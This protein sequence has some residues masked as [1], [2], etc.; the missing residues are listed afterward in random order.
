MDNYKD[1]ESELSAQ[2]SEN[3]SQPEEKNN[4]L[5]SDMNNI[6]SNKKRKNEE[7]KIGED[8]GQDEKIPDDYYPDKKQLKRMN[9]GLW[10]AESKE[11]MNRA[12]TILLILISLGF[13]AFSLYS[14][15][16]YLKAG[17]PNR[18]LND[19]NLILVKN[20]IKPL[21]FSAI[22]IFPNA[23]K[24]DLAILVKNENPRF[25]A[26]FDYCF[27]RGEQ[28]IEC[29]SSFALPDSEKYI[30]AFAS[31]AFL[32]EGDYQFF[33]SKIS[34]NRIPRE[35]L[36]YPAFYQARLNLQISNLLFKPAA[37]RVS[38]NIDLNSLEFTINNSSA[39]SYYQAVLNI[40]IFN[41]EKLSGVNRQVIENFKSGQEKKINLNWAGDLRSSSRVEIMPEIDILN[42]KVFLQYQGN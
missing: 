24:N 12:L 28:E 39:F 36:D 3:L 2:E 9:F 33:I 13:F 31:D 38:G 37:S 29:G 5:F 16:I 34:W 20:E 23:L 7:A 40:L 27:K 15:S 11:N 14:L 26:N 10:L 42:N 6:F 8:S 19:D 35:I 30:I 18:N 25:Y 4:S 21:V 32:G 41:G 1:E 17:D 22:N